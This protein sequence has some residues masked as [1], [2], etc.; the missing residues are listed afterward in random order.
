VPFV[1]DAS[2]TAD[3]LF[4]DG[5][6]PDTKPVWALMQNDF[7]VVPAIWWYEI[8]NVL[9]MA[10]RYRRLQ[11]DDIGRAWDALRN[12]RINI[13]PR[14]EEGRCLMLARLHSLSFY[15]AAYVELA[16]RLGCALATR[17]RA[18]ARAALAEQIPMVEQGSAE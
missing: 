18:M 9:L 16:Q 17:D 13:D 10:E 8:R 5:G 15:D 11:V 6:S 4:P 12:L 7:A 3:L 2:A 1:L 14:L